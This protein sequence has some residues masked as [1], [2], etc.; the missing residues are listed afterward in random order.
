MCLPWI[1]GAG[2][3]VLGFLSMLLFACLYSGGEDRDFWFYNAATYGDAICLP[4]IIISAGLYVRKSEGIIGNYNKIKQ[5]F[6]SH[7]IALVFGLVGIG[8]Q[9]SWLTGAQSN[10][11]IVNR[12]TSI[13]IGGIRFTMKFTL[14]GWWHAVFFVIALSTIAYWVSRLFGI[15][16]I[17]SKSFY[18]SYDMRFLLCAFSF[19]S[20]L[21]MELHFSDNSES[22]FYENEYANNILLCFIVLVLLL[23]VL[24][25]VIP[26]LYSLDKRLF[27][28]IISLCAGSIIGVTVCDLI[29]FHNCNFFI[30]VSAALIGVSISWVSYRSD[31][32]INIGETIENLF[33]TVCIYACI[34]N[35]CTTHGFYEGTVITMSI[36]TC[37]FIFWTMLL[38]CLYA[39][40]INAYHDPN[41]SARSNTNR[42][43]KSTV[44]CYF[45]CSFLISYLILIYLIGQGECRFVEVLKN[46]KGYLS[47]PIAALAAHSIKLL[48]NPIKEMDQKVTDSAEYKTLKLFQYV[49]I[50]LLSLVCFIWLLKDIELSAK[51]VDFSFS[52]E[53]MG[54]IILLIISF[55]LTIVAS[56]F[57]RK[58]E[59]HSLRMVLTCILSLA[60][61]VLPII[62]CSN[63]LRDMN[64]SINDLAT[65]IYSNLIN[66]IGFFPFVIF[67]ISLFLQ[68]SGVSYL[69]KQSFLANS[70]LMRGYEEKPKTIAYGRN[71]KFLSFIILL[72]NSI[73]LFVVSLSNLAVNYEKLPLYETIVLFSIL[74]FGCCLFPMLIYIAI[75]EKLPEHS[76]D[77]V[78]GE[79]TIEI[80]KDGMC[81]YFIYL[82]AAGIPIY[83]VNYADADYSLFGLPIY[84]LFMMGA[85]YIILKMC[86][87]NNRIH[88]EA[89]VKKDISK[90][91]GYSEFIQVKAMKKRMMYNLYNHIIIQS[92]FAMI[93]TLLYSFIFACGNVFWSYLTTGNNKDEDGNK[94]T[95]V[96]SV[97]KFKNNSIKKYVPDKDLLKKL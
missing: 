44:N 48:F 13:V 62:I 40:K 78:N 52:M 38:C 6:I 37:S 31:G 58:L 10:W 23:C 51:T 46:I 80:A 36:C 49:K 50:F 42:S 4:G 93:A 83:L 94:L 43:L 76:I 27:V 30:I 61:Y 3:F 32:T 90:D 55:G 82:L 64:Y 63:N 12:S 85:L 1:I 74:L 17:L 91:I 92:A 87:E 20:T 75:G 67:S 24:M 15:R 81:A 95:F 79:P 71:V 73:L 57:I 72:G 84:A 39:E 19:C 96:Q 34:S 22:R 45:F 59:K 86:I 8:V 9:I 16:M 26:F 77:I 47:F 14:A 25:V 89:L 54:D 88:F 66:K 2:I 7:L 21:Y 28:E 60:I 35:F 97:I 41:Y 33:Y 70:Y 68:I 69:I 18:S 53:S 11:T 29:L 5:Q 65:V 56:C